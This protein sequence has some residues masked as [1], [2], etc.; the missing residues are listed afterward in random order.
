ML[1]L[2]GKTGVLH[3]FIPMVFLVSPAVSLA[4]IE[5]WTP[6]PEDYDRD[7]VQNSSDDTQAWAS[8]LRLR[9]VY[10]QAGAEKKWIELN[11]GFAQQAKSAA[12]RQHAMF[13]EARFLY[14]QGE[15][16]EA[17]AKRAQLG[18]I[19]EGWLLGPF[20]NTGGAAFDRPLEALDQPFQEQDVFSAGGGH[21]AWQPIRLRPRDAVFPI[22][23]W[24]T[25]NRDQ[26]AIFMV[27]LQ[28]DKRQTV[29][30][31]LSTA[32][33]VQVLLNQENRLKETGKK[34]FG[35]EQSNAL[36]PLRRGLNLLTIRTANSL[37]G[38]SLRARLTNV[39][40]EESKGVTV[41]NDA[42]SLRLAHRTKPVRDPDIQFVTP[43]LQQSD[44]EFIFGNQS[45]NEAASRAHR[46]DDQKMRILDAIAILQH[47][48]SYALQQ[49]PDPLIA[50]WTKYKAI[51]EKDD[52]SLKDIRS[53]DARPSQ[54]AFSA[55]QLGELFF[56]EDMSESRRWFEKGIAIDAKCVSCLVGLA[57][58]RHEQGFLDKADVLYKRAQKAA[59][60]SYVVQMRTFEFERSRQRWSL[61]ALSNFLRLVE[62]YPTLD[63]L[64]NAYFEVDSRANVPDAK[65]LASQICA[66]DEGSIVCLKEAEYA[67]RQSLLSGRASAIE[68]SLASLLNQYQTRLRHFPGSHWTAEK[69]LLLLEAYGKTHEADAF[70]TARIKDF[71][72]RPEPLALHAKLS[73]IRQNRDAAKRALE[74][75]LQI[76]PQNKDLTQT[77]EYIDKAQA[78]LE[79]R[80]G[81]RPDQ[82]LE[83]ANSQGAADTGAQ[84]LVQNMA[85]QF[86]ENGLARTFEEK[87]IRVVDA[88]KSESLRSFS[89]PFSGG[90]EFVD[91]L[92]AEIRKSD[93]SHHQAESITQMTNDGKANGVYTDEQ[94][95][96]VVFGKLDDGDI[97]H[98]RTEKRMRGMENLFG[99]FF[100]T[101]QPIQS[102]FPIHEWNLWIEGP[103]TRPV[104]WGGRGVPKP[105]VLRNEHTTQYHFSR[106]EVDRVVMEPSMPPFLEYADYISLSTY[107]DWSAMGRWYSDL[108]Q[109]QFHVG[110]ELRRIAHAISLSSNSVEQKV[111][112]TYEY[113]VT[114]TRYVGIE[115]GVHG[116]KPYPVQEVYRRGFG[117]C[118]DKASLMVALLRE[119]GV[120]ARIALVRTSNL[121]ALETVPASMWAFNHAIAYVPSLDLFL[122]GTAER[123]GWKELPYM[124]QGG[125]ALIIAPPGSKENHTLVQIPV[126]SA[127]ENRNWS[128]YRLKVLKDGTM[129][130][131]GREQFSGAQN[132]FIRED[133]ADPAAR[134]ENLQRELAELMPGIEITMFQVGDLS[135]N[136]KEV[137]Y[138]FKAMVPN[139]A[140]RKGDELIFPLSLY[141]HQLL[142][143]YA[144]ISRREQPVWVSYPWQTTNTMHYTLPDGFTLG[145][146][147]ESI[148]I[149]SGDFMFSQDI[150][151]TD[152]GFTVVETVQFPRRIISADG[153]QKFRSLLMRADSRMEQRVHIV[154]KERGGS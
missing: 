137:S 47:G 107:Q 82:Y 12:V 39:D 51:L 102:V 112:K 81:S 125:M 79:S 143:S 92:I 119:M 147:P 151:P 152:D 28:S 121:G 145:E 10:K 18:I 49:Q 120:D 96:N 154:T 105:T 124:D 138:A 15:E 122:D 84:I 31:R 2:I 89:I 60:D 108:I 71:T 32:G 127:A 126:S 22:G 80:F 123:S 20:E 91:V 34:G 83:V 43:L 55:A 139:R 153:Y 129:L 113:V 69:Y 13:E 90:R 23:T 149:Q 41:Q 70:I 117:D 118:K 93:G 68:A 72:A 50:L 45:P 8:Y 27:A 16:Q 52:L 115:L 58:L 134:R 140:V 75:A 3:G 44:L 17:S 100:G 76:T 26:Q 85:V 37:G 86:Y 94:W 98:L 63:S 48:Q 25:P 97:I 132:A 101:L 4:Q 42:E 131:E 74:L 99:D 30:L 61:T 77:L 150:A 1:K 6:V 62:R 133:M 106:Q 128:T 56:D 136:K 104:Y 46:D 95:M 14:K 29:V 54:V 64:Q 114:S 7:R 11:Q 53:K 19:S 78:G 144:P 141:P 35:W 110:E 146:I 21:V 65:R 24:L 142:K 38:W 130:L 57:R 40:G 148:E 87:I 116:W 66:I 109:E 73:L 33:Q 135:L 59:P 9:S 67:M 5:H 88:K 111:Q 36:L 103:S